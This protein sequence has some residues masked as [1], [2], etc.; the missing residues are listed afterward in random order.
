MKGF[1]TIPLKRP[2][3]TPL[4]PREGGRGPGGFGWYWGYDLAA[5][6]AE[7]AGGPA[8]DQDLVKNFPWEKMGPNMLAS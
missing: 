7:P 3:I 8:E 2:A 6:K 5:I 1:S 4:F